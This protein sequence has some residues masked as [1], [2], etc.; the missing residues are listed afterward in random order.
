MDLERK[1]D[2]DSDE[3]R[4]QKDWSGFSYNDPSA[5]GIPSS[6]E[7]YPLVPVEV[8]EGIDDAVEGRTMDGDDLDDA[9]LF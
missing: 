2:G 1:D 7:E 4:E 6:H 3:A 5:S 8:L 9:L